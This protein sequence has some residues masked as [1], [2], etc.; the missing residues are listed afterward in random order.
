M[1]SK[2][3]F[4]LIELLVVV[5]IIGILAAAALPQYQVAVEKARMTEAMTTCS[6]IKAAQDRYFLA[7]GTRT[8]DINELDIGLPGQVNGSN[9]FLPSGMA[10]AL[11]GGYVFVRNKQNTILLVV[12]YTGLTYMGY[13]GW[14]CQAKKNHATA[15]RVCKSLGGIKLNEPETGCAVSGGACTNYKL[16]L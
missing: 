8:T 1:K 7:N 14:T 12:P 13:I 4:T 15:Q 9:I 16:P 6:A 2:Q 3:A 10:V 5:L 11:S